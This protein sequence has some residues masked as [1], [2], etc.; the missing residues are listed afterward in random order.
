MAGDAILIEE[1]PFTRRGWSC[2]RSSC[3]GWSRRALIRCARRSPLCGRR[4]RGLELQI[5]G[6][7]QERQRAAD[8]RR[9]CVRPHSIYRS[10]ENTAQTQYTTGPDIDDSKRLSYFGSFFWTSFLLSFE[11]LFRRQHA[12][13]EPLTRASPNRCFYRP[14]RV[15]SEI[16]T[17]D[18]RVFQKSTWT[19]NLASRAPSASVGRSQA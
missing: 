4:G 6:A 18:G 15:T 16:D 11:K 7:Q 3:G 2:R 1:C 5:P 8:N 17:N 10:I 14:I 12:S 19:P 13:S 9:R